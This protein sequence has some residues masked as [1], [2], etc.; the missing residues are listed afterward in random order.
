M[1]D[2]IRKNIMGT[3]SFDGK[4]AGMR[5]AQDFIVYPVKSGDDRQQITI[6]SD[7]RIGQIELSTGNVRL[8]QPRK[9]GAYFVHMMG[10]AWAGKLNAEQLFSLKAQLFATASGKAGSNGIVYTDNSGAVEIFGQA[11]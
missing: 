9:G 8:S 11:A 2:N 4:F 7:S 3:L 6:Q 1:I 10:A 5:K